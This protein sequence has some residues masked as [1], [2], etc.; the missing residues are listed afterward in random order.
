MAK[1]RSTVDKSVTFDKFKWILQ[2]LRS[3]TNLKPALKGH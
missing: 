1:A 3:Q 2:Y